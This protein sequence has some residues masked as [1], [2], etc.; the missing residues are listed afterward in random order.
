MKDN[1]YQK[2]YQLPIQALKTYGERMKPNGI[3]ILD[4]NRPAAKQRS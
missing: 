2:P 3:S 1:N 4:R